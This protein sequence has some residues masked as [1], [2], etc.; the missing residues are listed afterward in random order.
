[1]TLQ[2]LKSQYCVGSLVRVDDHALFRL[3]EWNR[4]L[5]PAHV[6]HMIESIK[7]NNML[8]RNP[9]QAIW[10][11]SHFI[12][13]DGQHRQRAAMRL[14]QPV[15]VLVVEHPDDARLLQVQRSWSPD[16]YL[17][18]YAHHPTKP[19]D[20]YEWVLSVKRQHA[21][22]KSTT[23]M[24]VAGVFTK[25]QIL[26]GGLKLTTTK[27]WALGAFDPDPGERSAFEELIR[28]CEALEASGMTGMASHSSAIAL[29]SVWLCEGFEFSWLLH[30]ARLIGSRYRAMP[31]RQETVSSILDIYN[32]RKRDRLQPWDKGRK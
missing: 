15:G 18:F 6:A 31:T 1:M 11:G 20:G 23:F 10:D 4:E 32:F 8:D 16:D 9:I 5:K 28:Q 13:V 19:Y 24:N 21:W 30:Q 14:D 25:M 2:G 26:R 22:L 12:I 3:A 29:S 27:T 17:N 7:E